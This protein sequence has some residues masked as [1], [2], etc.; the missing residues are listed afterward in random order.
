MR[1]NA[2]YLLSCLLDDIGLD[3][4]EALTSLVLAI[5]ILAEQQGPGGMDEAIMLEDAAHRLAM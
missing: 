5:K 3:N 1:E 2:E 4:D